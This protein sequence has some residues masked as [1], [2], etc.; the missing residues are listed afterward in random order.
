MK[1]RC[2]QQTASHNKQFGALVLLAL[3]LRES[4][5]WLYNINNLSRLLQFKINEC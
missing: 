3:H 5:A 2:V 4:S 1:H